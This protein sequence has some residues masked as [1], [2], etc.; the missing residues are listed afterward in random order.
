M[1]NLQCSF[2]VATLPNSASAA[3]LRAPKLEMFSL[4]AVGVTVHICSFIDSLPNLLDMRTTSRHFDL[5][6]AIELRFTLYRLVRRFIASPGHLLLKLEET[7]TSVGGSA[8]LLFFLRNASFHPNNLDLFVPHDAYPIL[9]HHICVEQGGTVERLRTTMDPD[10]QDLE[11]RSLDSIATVQ[12]ARGHILVHR[13]A[14]HEALAP[15]ARS[16]CSAHVTFVNP[17]YFGTAFPNLLFARRA[18]VGTFSFDVG[19]LVRKYR[20]LGFD[21]RLAT[22]MWS[23]LDH[24]QCAAGHWACHTQPRTFNDAG[25]LC[26]PMTSR[27]EERPSAF[28]SDMRWRLDVRPCGGRCL[29][30]IDGGLEAGEYICMM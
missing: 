6:V 27:M 28:R 14:N 9:L 25:A 30:D 2:L 22:H 4:P 11:D 18:I 12:T 5:A 8:A 29:E 20:N 13:S 10:G 16:W 23:D 26:A 7:H 19:R 1:S 3:R 21:F 17:R 24:P 15:V